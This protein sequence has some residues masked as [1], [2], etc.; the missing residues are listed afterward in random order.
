MSK[1]RDEYIASTKHQ[2]DELNK[3]MDELEAK[4]HVAKQDARDAYKAEMAKL[5]AQSKLA[6][7]KFDEFREAG[8]DAW[9]KSVA[10]MEKYRDAFAHSFNYFKSQV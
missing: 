1:A 10:E 9:D 7:D 4:A 2:L 3:K 8:D 6:M 5:R